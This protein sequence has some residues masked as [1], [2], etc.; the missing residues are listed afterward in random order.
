MGTVVASIVEEIRE[1]SDE[2]GCGA[3]LLR[4]KHPSL[5]EITQ[6]QGVLALP[7]SGA[8]LPLFADAALKSTML[9]TRIT[10]LQYIQ[11]RR[12]V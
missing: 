5:P 3:K 6:L 12:L 10:K 9:H 7:V 4:G 11:P 1:E 8:L 2:L